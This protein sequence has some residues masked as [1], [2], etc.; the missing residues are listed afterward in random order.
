MRKRIKRRGEEFFGFWWD[1]RGRR[2]ERWGG[3]R[4]EKEWMVY[5][6]LG[7]V[8]VR[9]EWWDRRWGGNG[10]R[11]HVCD[12]STLGYVTV[13]EE[14]T[15]EW[16]NTL[17]CITYL[18]STKL[19]RAPPWRIELPSILRCPLLQCQSSSGSVGKSI[20]PAFKRPRF[21]SLLSSLKKEVLIRTCLRKR[22]LIVSFLLLGNNSTLCIKRCGVLMI[23][24]PRILFLDSVY[25]PHTNCT[26][27]LSCSDRIQINVCSR[28]AFCCV[29]ECFSF[30][31]NT[32]ITWE[33]TLNFQL[34]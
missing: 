18:L 15:M 34:H 3:G 20:W 22:R 5:F 12:I 28:E 30:S 7:N 8:I 13:W 10:R 6:C 32:H 23:S 2:K 11:K 14:E 26:H 33:S 4:E 24:H 17:I 16:F 29:Y 31:D 9:E 21:I 19:T 1:G 27:K 25:L